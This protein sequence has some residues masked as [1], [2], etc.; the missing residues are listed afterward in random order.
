MIEIVFLLLA[1]ILGG[2]VNSIAGGGSFITFPALLLVGVPP[3]AAN[4]TN[5]FA[6]CSGYM[7]GVYALRRDL[8]DSR[9]NLRRYVFFSLVGG[10]AGA[11]LLLQTPEAIFRDAVPWLLLFATLLFI[12]GGA[13][14]QAL[15]KLATGHRHASHLGSAL[16]GMLLLLVCVYGGFFNAGLGIVILSYLA[17]AGESNINTMNGIKLL[18]SSVVSLVAIVLFV[19]DGVIV[20]REGLIVLLGTLIGGYLAA[21]YSRQLPQHWVRRSIIVASIGITVY[22]FYATYYTWGSSE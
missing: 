6:A 5:T 13:L 3:I 22:F 20:W 9:L 16:L 10:V 11:W 7:S 17:L 19:M 8:R 14:N 4:A 21:H 15:S 1:G 2:M 12:W 18:V